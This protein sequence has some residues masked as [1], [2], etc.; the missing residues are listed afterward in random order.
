MTESTMRA[1]VQHGY[2]GVEQLRL[3]HRPTP[4]PGRHEVLVRVHAVSPDS[5]TIHLLRGSPTLVRAALGWARPRQPVMGLAFAGIVVALGADVTSGFAIGDRVAGSATAAF[6]DYVAAPIAKLARVPDAVELTDA[7]TLPVSAGTAVQAIRDAARVQR[8]QR[9][10]IIGAG[11]GVGSFLVQLAVDAGAHVT[12]IASAAKADFVRSL[13]A[14]RVID[15][16]EQSD[17]KQW[18]RFDVVIDTADGRPL[19]VL[20]RAL[21]DRGTLVIVGA[22]H[23][24]GPMLEGTDRQLRA[25]LVDPWVRHRIVPVMQRES[26]D[27]VAGLLD[28]VAERRLRPPVEEV[29]PVEQA[30]HSI[31]RLLDRQV[32]G[33]TV[34]SFANEAPQ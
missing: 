1:L 18:G 3:E 17:P 20:R 23:V 27:E 10:L 8:G 28:L 34:I 2:G 26:G 22:D 21:T 31:Q 19:R 9:V 5:G 14:E 13:G 6:A 16:R 11:G 32:L 30:E 4:T 24:G 7:S 15:Y 29:V 25:M 12:G 33:K